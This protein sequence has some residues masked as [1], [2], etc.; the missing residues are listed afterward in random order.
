LKVELRQLSLLI[1]GMNEAYLFK[2]DQYALFNFGSN[3]SHDDYIIGGVKPITPDNWASLK[4]MLPRKPRVGLIVMIT[5]TAKMVVNLL[6]PPE[7]D[8]L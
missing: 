5:P 7:R 1:G 6:P 2:G 8:D 4:E 3:S